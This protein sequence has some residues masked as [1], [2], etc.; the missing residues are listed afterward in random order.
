MVIR[1]GL[2]ILSAIIV[3]VGLYIGSAMIIYISLIVSYMMFASAINNLFRMKKMEKKILEKTAKKL[4][5]TTVE[6]SS[7]AVSPVIVAVQKT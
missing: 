1:L 3:G 2:V 5:T 6:N 7:L 4:E